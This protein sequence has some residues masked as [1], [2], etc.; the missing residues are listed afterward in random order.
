MDEN[1]A[2]KAMMNTLTEVYRAR[3]LGREHPSVLWRIFFEKKQHL[4][5]IS[6]VFIIFVRGDVP[7]CNSTA[8]FHLDNTYR[9][10]AQIKVV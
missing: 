3:P 1:R 2:T 10:W 5:T 8:G 9:S 7:T 6:G 4:I